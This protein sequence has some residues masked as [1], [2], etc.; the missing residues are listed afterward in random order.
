MTKSRW[1]LLLA[2]ALTALAVTACGGG[3]GD[4]YGSIA[5]SSS[6]T[7]VAIITGSLTQ[8][9]ANESARDKCD[10]DDCEVVLQFEECGAVS[11]ANNKGGALIIASGQGGTAF[12]A[13]TAANEAC[14][15]SGGIGCTQ[16]PNL[17]AQCN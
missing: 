16:S 5:V 8:S 4:G 14:T 10:A 6:T 9:I 13:Q 2:T 1:S 11:V 7:N 3:S 12:S 17:A 15:A